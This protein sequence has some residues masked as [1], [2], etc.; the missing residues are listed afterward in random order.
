V[1]FRV[2]QDAQVWPM[3]PAG[4]SNSDIQYARGLRPDFSEGSDG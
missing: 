2:G 3:V 4:T 1:D